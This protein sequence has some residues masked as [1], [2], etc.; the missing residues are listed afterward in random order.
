MSKRE[1]PSVLRMAFGWPE[2]ATGE[3][4]RAR[5]YSGREEGAQRTSRWNA[6]AIRTM[7][8]GHCLAVWQMAAN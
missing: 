3:R 8:G 7:P 6:E 5:V 4:A 2:A 1:K